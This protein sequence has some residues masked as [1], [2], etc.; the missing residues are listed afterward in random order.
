[1]IPADNLSIGTHGSANLLFPLCSILQEPPD[2]PILPHVLR[3]QGIHN[4]FVS[5]VEVKMRSMNCPER[6]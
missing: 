3:I 1:M 6:L 2:S 4:S 5:S